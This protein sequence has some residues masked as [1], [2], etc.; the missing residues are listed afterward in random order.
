MI[1]QP[2]STEAAHQN[3]PP[4]SV[5]AQR[6]EAIYPELSKALRTFADYVLKCPFK[7]AGL[8]IN[9]T[10]EITGV[11]VASANRFARAL[12]F[13]GYAEFR[14]EL[15][16]G[17]MPVLEPVE[18]LRRKLSE[19][20]STLDV[21]AASLVE[22]ISNLQASLGSL[23]SGRVEQAVDMIIAARRIFIVAFDNAAG[24]AIILAHRLSSLGCDA[25]VVESGAGTLSS[26]RH[27]S[28]LNEND[29]VISIAFPRYLRDTVSMTRLACQQAIPVLVIT[30]SQTSPLA[31]LGTV[32][33]YAHAKRSFASTSDAAILAMLEALAAGVANHKP[34]A[35]AAAERLA[36]VGFYWFAYPE[37]EERIIAAGAKKQRHRGHR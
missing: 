25:R 16:R 24:L 10:V 6:I 2:S 20:S 21:V 30:D 19:E 34:G 28:Q 5:V 13:E 3:L 4:G 17:M 14:A 36:D 1:L 23:D 11:S 22:D 31:K 9:D 29:L 8:S 33:I 32:S 7:V 12:G 27:I 15:L 35:A 18:K 26:A 37:E